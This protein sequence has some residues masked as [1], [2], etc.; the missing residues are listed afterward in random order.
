VDLDPLTDEDATLL[1]GLISKH[2]EVTQSPRAKWILESWEQMLPKF[3]KV[4]PQEYKHA[5]ERQAVLAVP[6]RREEEVVHG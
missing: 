1:H 5:L 4:F 2:A 6:A 3:I